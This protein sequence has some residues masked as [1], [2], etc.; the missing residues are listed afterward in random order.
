MISNRFDI[1]PTNDVGN[2]RL[3]CRCK[4]HPEIELVDDDTIIYQHISFDGRELL[5]DLGFPVPEW[6]VYFT[7][8]NL[9]I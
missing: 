8:L 6:N 1:V 9:V 7:N 2:H 4:C 5:E 3:D